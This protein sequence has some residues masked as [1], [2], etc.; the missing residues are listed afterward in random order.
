MVENNVIVNNKLI[1]GFSLF[2]F[3]ILL[4]ILLIVYFHERDLSNYVHHSNCYQ[5]VSD[6][7]VEAGKSSNSI[8]T[9]CGSN[10]Q[11]RCTKTSSSLSDAIHFS[12]SNN[13][14]K[15]VHNEKTGF[16]ALLSSN[17]TNYYPSANSNIY[18]KQ[19]QRLSQSHNGAT[20]KLVTSQSTKLAPSIAAVSIQSSNFSA[21]KVN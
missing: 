17:N 7:A 5:P 19:Q 16:T 21:P 11:E 4:S 14:T 10:G 2:S 6:Y 18:T 15:F 8:L 13:A 1:F 3:I 12:N 20:K 9:I